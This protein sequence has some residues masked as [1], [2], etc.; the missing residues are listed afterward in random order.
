MGFPKLTFP[1]TADFGNTK[2]WI[3]DQGPFR[4]GEAVTAFFDG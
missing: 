4:F 1:L 3:G 2:Y